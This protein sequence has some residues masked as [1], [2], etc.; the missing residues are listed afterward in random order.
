MEDNTVPEIQRTNLANVVLLLKSL[1]IHDLVNFDFM[2]PPPAEALLR[3]LEQ[4]GAA[5][6]ADPPTHI[7]T[8]TVLRLHTTPPVLY[9]HTHTWA[10]LLIFAIA[11]LL[12]LKRAPTTTA[13]TTLPLLPTP[14]RADP[15][16]S[17]CMRWA[18]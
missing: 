16:I 7:H 6:S 15:V 12:P 8:Y 2:D 17:S 10:P 3:A 11:S 9:T 4:V 13:T 5:A 14:P 1:G 18:R